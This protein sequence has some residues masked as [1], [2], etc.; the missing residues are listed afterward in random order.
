MNTLKSNNLPYYLNAMGATVVMW[1]SPQC[2]L[3]KQQLDQVDF[4]KLG[5]IGYEFLYI[6]G[7]NW[8]SLCDEWDIKRF[9]TYMVFNQHT[10]MIE[11]VEYNEFNK[12]EEI[13][14]H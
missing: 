13:W 12:L 6:D 3:C 5:G 4:E 11:R 14:K 9:P 2:K 8:D 10:E 1:A 7:H